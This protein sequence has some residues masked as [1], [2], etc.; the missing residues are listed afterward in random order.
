MR[1]DRSVAARKVPSLNESLAKG[2]EKE[3]GQAYREKSSRPRCTISKTG[4]L[5]EQFL[6]HHVV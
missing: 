1:S 4:T 6:C 5:P 3:E 2:E